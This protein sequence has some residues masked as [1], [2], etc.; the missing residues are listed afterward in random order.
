MASVA[1]TDLSIGGLVH[2]VPWTREQVSEIL[3]PHFLDFV[4]PRATKPD[5][6]IDAVNLFAG[7]GPDVPETLHV[8]GSILTWSNRFGSIELDSASAHC[9]LSAANPQ[10]VNWILRFITGALLSRHNGIVVH[11]AAIVHDQRGHLYLGPSGA[12]K[13]TLSRIAQERGSVVLGDESVV[14]RFKENRAFVYG[15]PFTRAWKWIGTAG[16]APLKDISYLDWTLP[17][18]RTPIS[19]AQAVSF[20]SRALFIRLTDD[21]LKSRFLATASRLVTAAP[22]DYLSYRLDAVPWPPTPNR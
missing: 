1:E 14:V 15:T 4:V 8:A 20:V 5:V 13:S 12:G 6:T 18:G 22:M 21:A 3:G 16:S 10:H 11:G 19:P 2:R 9:A 17:S 7:I